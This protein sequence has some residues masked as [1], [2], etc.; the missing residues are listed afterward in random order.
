MILN[1]RTVW[2]LWPGCAILVSV[3]L[4]VPGRIWPILIP[5]AFATFVFYDLEAGVPL[6]SIAWFI[7]ADTVQVLTSAL[8]L[9]Y[10]FHGVPRLNSVNALAKYSFFAVF[11]APFGAAFLAAFGIGG[12]YWDGWRVCFLSEALA[13]VTLTP[14]ILSWMSEGPAWVRKPRA[15]HLEAAA[16]ITGLILLSHLIFATS[17]GRGYSPALLYSLIPFLLWSALR[18]GSI[19]V[20]SSVIL[21]SF[22]TIWGAV[23]ARGPFA[24][25][26]TLNGMV[27]LQLFLIFAA[28]PFMVLAALVEDSKLASGELAVSNE[29]VR[30]AMEAGRSI[31]WDLAVQGK[32]NVWIGDLQTIFGISSDTDMPSA[33]DFILYVYP[34]DRPQVS[35]ALRDARQNRQMYALEF[36]IIRPDGL[37]RWLAARGRFYY[38]TDD[39]AERML[40]VSLDI[41]E[42]K[43][44]ERAV[45]ESEERFRLAARAGKMFAYEWDPS[46]DAILRSAESAQ[47]L[48]IDEAAQITGQQILTN[49]HPDDR[50][51]LEA[52]VAK[53]SPEEPNL[54]ISYRMVRPDGIVIWVEDTGR[55]FFDS[56]GRK[57]GAVGMVADVTDRKMAE[58]ALAGV[59]RRLIEA[60]ELERTRIARELHDDFSQRLALMTVA[61]EQLQGH[62][63]NLSEVRSRIRELWKQA[64]EMTMD[65]QSLSHELHSSKL[66]YLGVVAAI[67]GFCGE[68]GQQQK[69]EIKFKS[70]DVPSSLSPDISLC[71]FRVLQEALHNSA[72]H[73]GVRCVEGR[74]WGTSDEIHLTVSDFGTGFDTKRAR[75]GRGI[76][77]ISME[78]RLKLVKGTLSIE[79]EPQRGT[80]VHARVPISS[81]SMPIRA[82]G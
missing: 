72:K 11:L 76:G 27:S 34:D 42:R 78:E 21:V 4:L 55:A 28:M 25:Q 56:Q 70:H 17:D 58:E 10:R 66:E 3:L 48:G 77:L 15:Y 53:L 74:L 51:R 73:S 64:S 71:L 47:I 7:P 80:T 43:L 39:E 32:R 33:E 2:P 63:S 37:I 41:T 20:S 23:H 35:R 49:V 62:P 61:L 67:R 57:A 13:F 30:L 65:I 50:K 45:K 38:S 60:Q 18:F 24:E 14:A 46:T 82:T 19:G 5:A 1:P 29:R 54:L 22:Q 26:G 31:A 40:G 75:E 81:D 59:N 44:A 69:M 52:A 36:R 68:F 8:C 16:L 9:R 6:R 79:S 12:N